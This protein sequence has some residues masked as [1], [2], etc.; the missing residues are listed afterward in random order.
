M[1]SHGSWSVAAA[2][3]LAKPS[4]ILEQLAPQMHALSTRQHGCRVVQVVLGAGQDL[5]LSVA[6]NSM[7]EGGI[8][9]LAAHPYGN[10]AVQV[11]LRNVQV[12][13]REQVS[14]RLRPNLGCSEKES[15]RAK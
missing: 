5:D 14:Q 7:I 13:Q 15:R 3:R 10:Y 12:Q 2:F 1:D 9:A 6:M 8:P 11:L 4:F